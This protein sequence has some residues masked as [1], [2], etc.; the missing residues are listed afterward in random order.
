MIYL[1]LPILFLL[2]SIVHAQ[3]PSSKDLAVEVYVQSQSS[4]PLLQFTG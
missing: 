2:T 3:S 1:F 4:P